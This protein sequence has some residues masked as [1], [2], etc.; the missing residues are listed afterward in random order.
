MLAHLKEAARDRPNWNGLIDSQSLL[1]AQGRT[2]APG[3]TAEPDE[4]VDLVIVQLVGDPVLIDQLGVAGR[5]SPW[6]GSR[7]QRPPFHRSAAA[8]RQKA[9]TDDK[10]LGIDPRTQRLALRCHPDLPAREK[11]VKGHQAGLLEQGYNPLANTSGPRRL[12]EAAPVGGAARLLLRRRCVRSIRVPT[13]GLCHVCSLWIAVAAVG[14]TV[15]GS[16]LSPLNAGGARQVQPPAQRMERAATDPAGHCASP[17]GSRLWLPQ[18]YQSAAVPLEHPADGTWVCA[19]RLAEVA[20]SR[21]QL[22]WA[23]R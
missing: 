16:R 11:T 12:A 17:V 13:P 2:G 20:Q 8:I 1:E 7:Q 21:V 5:S 9:T 6:Q 14:L 10:S 23:L 4:F 22:H 18:Q 19:K 15:T 3:L